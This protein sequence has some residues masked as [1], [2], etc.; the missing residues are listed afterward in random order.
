MAASPS[1]RPS[2]RFAPAL[3]ASPR[4]SSSIPAALL[5][6]RHDISAVSLR[7]LSGDRF[8][9][10]QRGM[11]PRSSGDPFGI[12]CASSSPVVEKAAE[13]AGSKVST[14]VDVDLGN[15]S[16][17]IYIGSGLLDE[18]DLLQRYN[19]FFFFFLNLLF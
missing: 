3:S 18:P 4:R 2:S 7:S 5:V 12:C 15:R 8:G 10:K 17:P 16:Y 1:L 6:R 9:V 14:V 13:E 11:R 19:P